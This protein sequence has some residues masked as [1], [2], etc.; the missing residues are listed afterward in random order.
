ME[1]GFGAESLLWTRVHTAMLVDTKGHARGNQ[2]PS[3]PDRTCQSE[4]G[5]RDSGAPRCRLTSAGNEHCNRGTSRGQLDIC[6]RERS[7]LAGGGGGQ[8]GPCGAPLH[9]HLPVT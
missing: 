3:W 9:G 2:G 1:A 7:L 6:Q 8:A 4:E 5:T